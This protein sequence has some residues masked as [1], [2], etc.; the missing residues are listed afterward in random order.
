MSK[1][2]VAA[3]V[4]AM[5]PALTLAQGRPSKNVAPGGFEQIKVAPIMVVAEN[6][7]TDHL[8]QT[9]PARAA[10]GKYKT[11][12]DIEWDFV[13]SMNRKVQLLRIVR[14]KFQYQDNKGQWKSITVARNI[15]LMEAFA[16][17]DDGKTAFLDLAARGANLTVAAS[18]SLLGPAC[19]APGEILA[20]SHEPKLKIAREVHDDGLRWLSGHAWTEDEVKGYRGEKLL[21]SSFFQAGNY[22]YAVEFDFTD[23]GRIIPKLG[24]TAHN[25][26]NRNGSKQ[27]EG[28]V[29]VHV[30]CW[31]LEFDMT[32]SD[33]S[34]TTRGGPT[35]ND[36]RL[37][38][39]RF[40]WAGKRF[41][42]ADEPFGANGLAW[43]TESREGKAQWKAE[44]FT[45]LRVQSKEAKNAH[46]HPIAYDLLP[47]RTGSIRDLRE[48]G[49][50]KG[51]DMDFLNHDFWVTRGP[52]KKAY[53]DVPAIAAGRS[54]LKD[55]PATVWYSSPGL[56]VPR[57]EDFGGDSGTSSRSGLA[58]MN[59]V[60]FTLRPRNLFDSTP[61]YP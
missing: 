7:R 51:K 2:V 56:H 16:A 12:W 39:R 6:T 48:A 21:L 24:F 25:L 53:H 18:K 35:Q 60:E 46:T 52:S 23:D 4:I 34:T 9:F 28:D 26:F 49:S 1:W 61:L 30:G 27:T 13:P 44:E 42:I 43:E 19:V 11:A 15:E 40:D 54:P 41:R 22:T 37:M 17:Y 3:F 31:R 14:A 55:Q 36:Y 20:F 33:S 10:E 8:R 58:L 29:H 45:S 59:W 47:M 38:S 50:A 5:A 32:V 57:G